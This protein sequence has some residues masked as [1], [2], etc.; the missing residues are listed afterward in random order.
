MAACDRAGTVAFPVATVPG[1]RGLAQ[2]LADIVAAYDPLEVLVGLPRSL[3]GAEGPA[4]R[5][6]RAFAGALAA[7]LATRGQPRPVRLVDERL[8]TV[9]AA[10]QLRD[11]G[12]KARRQRDVVDAAAAVAIL[13]H[14]LASEDAQGQPPG[15]LVS[16][17]GAPSRRGD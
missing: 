6:V 17:S 3:S 2:R 11:S 15:E 5:K 9:T 13:D 12:R 16:A 7:D 1:G 8:T 10:R 4:A 14:A